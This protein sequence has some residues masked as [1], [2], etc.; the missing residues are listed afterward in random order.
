[1]SA[2]II[3]AAVAALLL[4]PEAGAQ[5]KADKSCDCN[6]L[7]SLQQ[8]VENAAYAA[9]FFRQ[10]AERLAEVE[11]EQRE[12]N[13]HGDPSNPN[14]GRS[15]RGTS[16]NERDRIMATEFRPPHPQVKDY[17][18]PASVAMKGLACYQEPTEL[19]ELRKGSPCKEIADIVLEHEAQHRAICESMGWS[20]YWDMLP[21]QHAAE[22]VE[23][24]VEQA[25]KMHEQL[26]RVVSE[27]EWSM[28]S[29]TE[30]HGTMPNFSATWLFTADKAKLEGNTSFGA[31]S[32]TL[33]GKTRGTNRITQVRIAGQS[34]K[35]S[36]QFNDQ[37]EYEMETDGFTVSVT[38]KNSS[39]SGQ[40][41]ITCQ[42]AWGGGMTMRPAGEGGSG[43]VLENERLRDAHTIVR[44]VASMPFAQ[45]MAAASGMSLTGT[46]QA[47]LVCTPKRP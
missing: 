24:Y 41:T 8:E 7:E 25:K 31:D 35:A 13:E 26:K 36:G 21:S 37:I 47:T 44:D 12:L 32:W 6:N 4:A 40:V 1:M 43:P 20:A 3:L 22:E 2:R 29:G 23:R 11:R 5:G 30:M 42:S 10:L 18:G 46:Y 9:V 19:E 45:N 27:G 39:V 14:H 15:V 34:C 33:K 17:T 28:E 16:A 38:Q